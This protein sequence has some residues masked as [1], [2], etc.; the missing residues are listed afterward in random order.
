MLAVM[1]GCGLRR[2][3]I[4]GLNV[5]DWNEKDR[6]FTFVGKGNKQRKVFLPPTM[7]DP[8]KRWM[9]IR[10][11][12]EGAIF[13]AIYKGNGEHEFFKIRNMLPS[14]INR[15]VQRRAKQ[16]KIPDIS[17]HDL[18]RTFATRMLEAGIDLFVLQQSMG[19]ANLA[20]TTR[21]D[22]RGDKAKEKAAKAL[23]F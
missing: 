13:P 22:R 2:A 18:R 6:T 15:I 16:A 4:T 12:D 1:M 19:H 3:E 14:S 17:P 23:R 7:L 11:F 8:F 5:T 20:T 9:N 10:G 21:Y